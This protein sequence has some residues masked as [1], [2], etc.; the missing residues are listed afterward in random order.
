MAEYDKQKSDGSEVVGW[1]S[2]TAFVTSSQLAHKLYKSKFHTSWM[3]WTKVKQEA[4]NVCCRL[5][6]WSTLLV[7][8]LQRAEFKFLTWLVQRNK[9]AR[10]RLGAR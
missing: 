2:S 6:R 1:R 4:T 7:K 3:Q 5:C 10:L 9:L 8:I